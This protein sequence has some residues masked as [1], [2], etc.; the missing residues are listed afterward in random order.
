ME[1][2]AE[3]SDND[4]ALEME[5]LKRKK[6]GIWYLDLVLLVFHDI[7]INKWYTFK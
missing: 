2:P 5:W 3:Y 4:D 7:L 1:D 6:V